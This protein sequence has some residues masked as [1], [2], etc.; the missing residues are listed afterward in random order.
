M[1]LS[2]A[3]QT[4]DVHL[5][6]PPSALSATLPE[7]PVLA[8]PILTRAARS[9]WRLARMML[10]SYVILAA[11]GIVGALAFHAY[12]SSDATRFESAIA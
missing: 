4:A 11:L 1:R 6:P 3:G 10:M 5:T 7:P 12:A 9:L 8:R 2:S